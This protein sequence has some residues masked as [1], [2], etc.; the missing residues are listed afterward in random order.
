MKGIRKI[1][2][3]ATLTT[4]VTICSAQITTEMKVG[5]LN[6][7]TSSSISNTLNLSPL[8]SVSAG[9]E[10][11]YA[12]DEHLSI[13]TGVNYNR[14]G[15]TTIQGTNVTVLGMGI[16][17]GVKATTEINYLNMPALLKIDLPGTAKIEP[18]IAAGPSV[19]YATSGKLR[20]SATA[21]L[22]FNVTNTDLV[23]NSP[24]YNRVQ[25]WGNLRAGMKIP[26]SANGHWTI[27]AGYIHSLT[28]LVSDNFIL[29]AGGRHRALNLSV[30]Y[31]FRF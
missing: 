19:A 16:P 20:T 28:D 15:F 4:A 26:Y 18:Y 30:G 24:N 29:D 27:E 1:L 2:A 8:T 7:H 9:L 10:M 12:M 13:I 5:I 23:L 22:D 3:A 14:H 6:S 25:L 11:S 21:L 31:G 17:L